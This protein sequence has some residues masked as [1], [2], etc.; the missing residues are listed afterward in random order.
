MNLYPTNHLSSTNHLKTRVR[1]VGVLRNV[2]HFQQAGYAKY[3][4]RIPRRYANPS[5]SVHVVLKPFQMETLLTEKAYTAS[6][7]V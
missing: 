5:H 6:L 1:S 4:F 7:E 2:T 3:S